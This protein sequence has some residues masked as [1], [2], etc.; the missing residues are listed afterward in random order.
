MGRRGTPWGSPTSCALADVS[1]ISVWRGESQ[2]A[3]MVQGIS[4][5][6]RAAGAL[7]ASCAALR[8]AARCMQRKRL[9]KSMH[10][11]TSPHQYC[12]HRIKHLCNMPADKCR[13]NLFF[14][15]PCYCNTTIIQT[16]DNQRKYRKEISSCHS[17]YVP[18]YRC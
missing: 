10:H 14:G 16:Q 2:P 6:F 5:R 12:P 11:R 4:R 15:A 18:P 3:W 8:T 9:R 17:V 1:G 7:A 13:N